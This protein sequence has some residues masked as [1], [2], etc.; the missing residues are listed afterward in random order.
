MSKILANDSALA[1]C[2]FE[3]YSLTSNLYYLLF[4]SDFIEYKGDNYNLRLTLKAELIL[5]L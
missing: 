5:T 2:N 3:S 4:I 1:V